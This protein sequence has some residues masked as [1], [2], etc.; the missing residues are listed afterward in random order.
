MGVDMNNWKKK[1]LLAFLSLAALTLPET[2]LISVFAQS[3]ESSEVTTPQQETII[4]DPNGSLDVE[5]FLNDNAGI[6]E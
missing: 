1:S 5:E 3:T 4:A 6:L 2:G